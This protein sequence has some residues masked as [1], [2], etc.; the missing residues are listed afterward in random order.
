MRAA[1]AREVYERQAKERMQVRKGE[2]AGTSKENLPDLDKGQ[3]R[4]KVGEAFGVSGKSVDHATK[5]IEKGTPE[6]AEAVDDCRIAVGRLRFTRR[7]SRSVLT[8]KAV[9]RVR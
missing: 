3:A 1:R 5:V 4:D 2:Q 6:L 8:Q 7:K 9:I